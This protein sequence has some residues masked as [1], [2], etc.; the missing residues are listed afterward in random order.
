MSSFPQDKP[1]VMAYVCRLPPYPGTIDRKAC[2]E[3]DIPATQIKQLEINE[4]VTLD[5]GTVVH[6]DEH[7]VHKADE[8]SFVGNISLGSRLQIEIPC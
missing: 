6:P 2:I 1:D 4:S 7:R 5:D 3:R 8:C